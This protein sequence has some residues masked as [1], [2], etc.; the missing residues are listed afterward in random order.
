[1]ASFSPR[2][3]GYPTAMAQGPVRPPNTMIRFIGQCIYCRSTENLIGEEHLIP[4]ALGG[5]EYLG[6][7]ACESCRDLTG[8]AESV[9]LQSLRDFRMATGLGNTRQ[10]AKHL[11][12]PL[13]KGTAQSHEK[14][15]VPM[16]YHPRWVGLPI[17]ER[18]G[19][20][21]PRNTQGLRLAGGAV[22]NFRSLAVTA[23]YLGTRQMGMAQKMPYEAFA[24]F[25][26][27]V[28]YGYAIAK[29]GL[30]AMT[31]VM[32][33]PAIRGEPSLLGRWVGTDTTRLQPSGS[34][35]H[36]DNTPIR[37][38]VGIGTWP[39]LD[40]PNAPHVVRT[41]QF[42]SHVEAPV[43]E[44]IIGTI[45]ANFELPD[46][47]NILRELRCDRPFGVSARRDSVAS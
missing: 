42:F 17:F 46:H 40:Q 21:F 44:V 30:D 23:E 5:Y 19:F 27:K 45:P 9:W 25:V 39:I 43:Y 24:R 2:R 47:F 10:R 38:E 6:N 1:M 4:V 3:S 22:I 14:V 13:L 8:R 11:T 37:H 26:S 15:R 41:V 31:E 16:E 35:K 34:A 33:L 18:A 29:L 7:A 20:L 28:A 32:V 12:A 36:Y